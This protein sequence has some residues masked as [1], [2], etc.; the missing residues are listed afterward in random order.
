MTNPFGKADE[1][2]DSLSIP[3]L[4]I[5]LI[6]KIWLHFNKKWKKYNEIQ[7]TK[8]QNGLK[9]SKN[10]KSSTLPRSSKVIN[11]HIQK[12]LALVFKQ[13]NI[14]RQKLAKKIVIMIVQPPKSISIPR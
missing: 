1:T 5:I 7:M 8:K 6:N 4:N 13:K 11:I 3:N 12:Q 9:Y 14:V 2:G 10:D